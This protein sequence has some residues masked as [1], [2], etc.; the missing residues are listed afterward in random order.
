MAV[1]TPAALSLEEFSRLPHDGERHE[2]NAGEL[3]TMPP[4]K[5]L[6]S[7]IA[8]A[9]LEA[10]Q[11]YLRQQG[12]SRAIPEAGYVLSRGPL[13]VCQ[14]DVSVL[15]KE[16]IQS[17]AGDEYFEGAP[18]LAVEIVSPSDSAEGLQLKVSQYLV[19]GSKQ[20]WVLYPKSKQVHIFYSDGTSAV[21]NDT[22]TLTGG[23]FLPEFSVQ[24][25]DL[26]V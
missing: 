24:V 2:L 18:E 16:R 22:Q 8:L 3:I 7:L 19:A 11:A 4:A 9:V 21:L 13:T 6:H 25:A 5:S 15:S 12:L 20:V 14:P 26:F 1:R 23:D 10:L 17:T